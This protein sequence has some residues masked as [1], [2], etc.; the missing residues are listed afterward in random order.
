MG[1]FDTRDEGRATAEALQRNLT[2]SALDT[3]LRTMRGAPDMAFGGQ[4]NPETLA[5]AASGG[6]LQG[7]RLRTLLA[8]L[9]RGA[10]QPR[11]Q[12]TAPSTTAQF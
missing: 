12:R 9:M 6:V 2:P 5:G 7:D 11:P 1:L 4:Q 10:S 3:L 8:L